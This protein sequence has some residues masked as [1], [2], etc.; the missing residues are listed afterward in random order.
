MPRYSQGKFQSSVSLE[1]EGKES[2][3]TA[4]VKSYEILQRAFG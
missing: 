1:M 2:P 3:E 4:V